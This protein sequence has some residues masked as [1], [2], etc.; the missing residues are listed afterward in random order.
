MDSEAKLKKPWNWWKIGFFV[1]LFVFEVTREIAVI[2]SHQT[3][4][5]NEGLSVINADGYVVARGKWRR[6]DYGSPLIPKAVSIECW[7]HTGQCVEA[8]S[9][10]SDGYVYAP[11]LDWFDAKF[12]SDGVTYENNQPECATYSVRIDLKLE[13]VSASRVRKDNPTNK[14]CKELEPRVAMQLVEGF[15]PNKEPFA[16]HFV[17]ILD[18]VSWVIKTLF[19]RERS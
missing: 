5:V 16:G 14:L 13:Q 10:T 1:I 17:P 12:T 18:L 15:E 2:S 8:H 9:N 3:P 11:R 4:V 19:D 7:Q 6:T